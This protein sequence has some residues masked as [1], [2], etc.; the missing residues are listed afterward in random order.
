ML[1]IR[2]EAKRRAAQDDNRLELP[3]FRVLTEVPLGKKFRVE[4]L[5]PS[6]SYVL[7]SAQKKSGKTTTVINLIRSLITGEPFLDEFR[8]HGK[9]RVALVDFEMGEG[10][11]TKWLADAGLLGNENLHTLLLRG[12]AKAFDILDDSRFD[13]LATQLSD[14]GIDVL[15]TDP[16][17]PL[18]RAYGVDENSNSEVGRVIDRLVGLKTEAGIDNLVTAHH[19]GKSDEV[20]ARGASVL[21]DTPD[22][23]WKLKR[24]DKER[25]TKLEARGR[26]VEVHRDIT[27]DPET[28]RLASFQSSFAYV[29]P[30]NK[31]PLLDALR[32]NGGTMSGH[33]VWDAARKLGY[34][35]RENQ[36]NDDLRVL[37][38]SREVVN[39]GS[40]RRRQWRL[41]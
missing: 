28:R 38:E 12:R 24:N 25:V 8:V 17:G 32:A 33:A 21:E 31:K 15:I 16:I 41:A 9:A 22:A 40:D 34:Q 14:L 26:D 29:K 30:D 4:D 13:K 6:D 11:L 18:L 10:Q 27:F 20:G 5:M 19:H 35:A 3:E 36:A 37:E 1:S 39:E 23:I 7:L 2:A